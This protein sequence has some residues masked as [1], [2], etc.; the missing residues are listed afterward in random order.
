MVRPKANLFCEIITLISKYSNRFMTCDCPKNDILRAVRSLELVGRTYLHMIDARMCEW[1]VCVS[2]R[3]EELKPS[4]SLGDNLCC[5]QDSVLG[6]LVIPGVNTRSGRG[7]V[8]G[9]GGG[10]GGALGKQPEFL[11]IASGK[12]VEDWSVK[13][14]TVVQIYRIYDNTPFRGHPS[15]V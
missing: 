1:K 12:L 14:W 3:N 4:Q 15:K 10:G 7:Y 11:I 9:S 6:V 5:S 2:W 13:T 8:C